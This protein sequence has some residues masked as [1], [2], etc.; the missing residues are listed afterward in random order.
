VGGGQSVGIV[1]PATPEHERG[2]MLALDGHFGQIIGGSGGSG[3]LGQV[4]SQP[5]VVQSSRGRGPK[6]SR[7]TSA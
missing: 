6:I 5:R 3:G 4:S 1:D 2:E 7:P